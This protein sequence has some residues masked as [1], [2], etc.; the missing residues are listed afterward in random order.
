MWSYHCPASALLKIP[1]QLVPDSGFEHK[2]R[3]RLESVGLLVQVSSVRQE[4]G[5]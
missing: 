2:L 4:L 3:V 1:V 5:S